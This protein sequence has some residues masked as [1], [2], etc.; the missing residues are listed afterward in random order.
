MGCDGNAN[1]A[2]MKDAWKRGIRTKKER[3]R[4]GSGKTGTAR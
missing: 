4:K 3:E 1:A 2:E